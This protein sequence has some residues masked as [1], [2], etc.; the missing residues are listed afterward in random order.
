MVKGLTKCFCNVSERAL[1]GC[2]TKMK[3]SGEFLAMESAS[4]DTI[5]KPIW[6]PVHGMK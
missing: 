1:R 2:K 3:V 6:K 5:I 4:N